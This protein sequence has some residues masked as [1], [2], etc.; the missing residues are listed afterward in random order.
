VQGSTPLD[1]A[2]PSVIASCDTAGG[3]PAAGCHEY[4]DSGSW[5]DVP[6]DARAERS[7]G[8]AQWCADRLTVLLTATLTAVL[9]DEFVERF[10]LSA[11][12]SNTHRSRS[13]PY[14]WRGSVAATRVAVS[15]PSPYAAIVSGV[16]RVKSHNDPR[17]RYGSRL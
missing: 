7:R 10:L 12:H 1:H 8:I 3:P 15:F 17:S 6:V 4:G 13:E 16:V 2:R 5:G 11:T 14:A 9:T